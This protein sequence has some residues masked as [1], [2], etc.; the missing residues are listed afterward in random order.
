MAISNARVRGSNYSTFQWNGTAIA[1]LETITDLGVTTYGPVEAIHPLGYEHP[2]EFAVPRVL[3]HGQLNFTIR[4]LWEK[5]VWQHL[6][7]LAAAN[8]LL[9]VWKVL[10]A[11]AAP[12]TCQT[13]I[14]PPAGGFVRTKTYHN[15]VI[16]DIDDTDAIT[17][18]GM[19]VART[20][21]CLYTHATR[22]VLA[23]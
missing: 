4:E 1:Y 15:V 11:S 17:I 7:G 20:I 21:G 23:V 18:A 6:S 3:S 14:R 9:D 8:D 16:N 5:P 10:A 12:L 2:T 13:I 22:E 19:T